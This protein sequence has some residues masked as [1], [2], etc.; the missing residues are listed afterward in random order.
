MSRSAIPIPGM[1]ATVPPMSTGTREPDDLSRA[2]ANEINGERHRQRLTQ[3][4][5]FKRAGIPRTS[6]VT[7]EKGTK[8]ADSTQLVKIADVLGIKTSTLLLRAEENIVITARPKTPA[9]K[10][11]DHHLRRFPPKDP[12]LKRDDSDAGDECDPDGLVAHA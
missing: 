9:E 5:V 8:V 2:I 10:A 1:G 6:Y 7:I 3:T 12:E 11:H 4:E